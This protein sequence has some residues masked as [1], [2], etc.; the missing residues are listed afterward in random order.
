MSNITRMMYVE[1]PN[2]LPDTSATHPPAD[3]KTSIIGAWTKLEDGGQINGQTL[4]QLIETAIKLQVKKLLNA[5][6]SLEKP[7][8]FGPK[9]Q[10]GYTGV[11][12]PPPVNVIPTPQDGG[13]IRIT[14]TVPG[15]SLRFTAYTG[16]NPTFQVSY[17]LVITVKIL[18]PVSLV[19]SNP[20]TW[21]A[22]VSVEAQV[23]VLKVITNNVGAFLCDKNAANEVA[24]A[25][26]GQIVSVASLAPDS[27]GEL[28]TIVQASANAGW[29]HLLESDD[30][31]GTVVLTAVNPD[32]TVNG[33]T[34]DAIQINTSSAGLVEI[35]GQGQSATFQGPIHSITVN[36]GGGTNTIK[37]TGAPSNCT[38]SVQNAQHG[39]NTVTIGGSGL[40][41]LAGTTIDI[42][43]S[44]GSTALIVDDTGDA[45]AR[46]AAI[47]KNAVTFT[48]LTTVNYSGNIASLKVL[49]GSGADQFFIATTA[50]GTAT[51]VDA[52]PGNNTVYA[53]VFGTNAALASG[54]G[55]VKQLAGPL[56]VVDAAGQTS[57]TINSSDDGYD[58]YQVYSDHVAF[59]QGPTIKFQPGTGGFAIKGQPVVPS[60]GV[61][62]L[63]IYGNAAGNNIQ[64][65]SVGPHTKVTLWGSA[66][67][68]LAGSAVGSV[69]HDIYP[70]PKKPIQ[71]KKPIIKIPQVPKG[72]G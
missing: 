40:A 53:G 50:P 19:L 42:A 60:T 43:D 32:L 56:D 13:D 62:S 49:G 41:K 58:W 70:P 12:L 67:D 21:A 20:S 24:T 59:T 29:T 46:I 65:N 52:G 54:G 48:G 6:A 4:F 14:L 64:V 36:S 44:S 68:K 18:L 8:V 28:D 25:I 51:T 11:F 33:G 17:D 22:H 26:N 9:D 45:A 72:G 61:T 37:I 10:I 23:E 27:V 30:G 63:T 7:L 5:D 1:Q 71:P 34:N 3:L 57:L 39:K 55:S 35:S 69:T 16:S 2:T 47:T 31:A 66:T 15:N 38:V